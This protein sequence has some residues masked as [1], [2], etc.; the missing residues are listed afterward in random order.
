MKCQI[1][2][3][4]HFILIILISLIVII[5]L[6]KKDQNIDSINVLFNLNLGKFSFFRVFPF[7]AGLF[8]SPMS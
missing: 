8:T 6:H 1:L 5:K 4:L 7:F 2:N 3:Q